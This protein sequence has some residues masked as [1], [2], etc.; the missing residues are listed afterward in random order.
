M[1]RIWLLAGIAAIATAV[2]V[3]A[4]VGSAAPKAPQAKAAQKLTKVTLQLK[5]V[6]Q[7]QFAG[8]YAAKEKGYYSKAGLDVNLKVGGPDIT[9]E[10]VVVSAG[11]REFGLDWLPN[12]LATR[13]KGGKIVSIAQVFARS[14]M[15][16]I[17]WKTSGI[18]SI[19]K[20]RARRSASGA[21]ATSRSSSPH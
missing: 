16:E 14:G 12:L 1:K 20:M 3:G 21:A 2:V 13:E 9:P 5:W 15:T 19:S 11:R 18:D 6:T 8:Y 7:A 10:T 17:S 4:G